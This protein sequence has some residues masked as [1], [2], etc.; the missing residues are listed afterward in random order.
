[1]GPGRSGQ[2]A[3]A[4]TSWG[5]ALREPAPLPSPERLP[6]PE[7][8]QPRLEVCG[9]GQVLS[10]TNLAVPSPAPASF[11]PGLRSWSRVQGDAGPSRAA[12]TGSGLTVKT[13]ILGQCNALPANPGTRAQESIWGALVA[14]FPGADTSPALGT[15]ILGLRAAPGSSGCVGLR[16]EPGSGGG[17]AEPVS[18]P[19]HLPLPPPAPQRCRPPRRIPVGQSSKTLIV[20][21]CPPSGDKMS[22][23][24]MVRKPTLHR[25]ISTKVLLAE[26]RETPF[27][28]HCRNY[29]NTYRVGARDGTGGVG[30]PPPSLPV[31]AALCPRPAQMLQT[32]IQGL[33]DQVQELHRDLTKHHSLIRTEIMSEILQKSLQMDVQ[34][35]AHYSSV[36]MMRS[37]FEEVRPDGRSPT[38]GAARPHHRQLL[39]PVAGLGGD[40]P[41]GGE[42]AG[43]LR[44]YSRCPPGRH[45]RPGSRGHSPLSP[46]SPAPRPAAAAAGEQLPDHHHQADRA[47][48]PLHRQGEGAAGA[49]VSSAGAFG[50]GGPAPVALLAC[51][52]QPW[53]RRRLQEPREPKDEHT[54]T[55]LRIDD[56]SEAAQR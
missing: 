3:E 54:Q 13:W 38:L 22:T 17:R 32:E 6:A 4:A 21:G 27:A 48:R 36:E 46:P 51:H 49:Q 35:A 34:I 11:V 24:S 56:N 50:A 15:A 16:G 30:Q 41:E 18:P 5:S 44:R 26:G 29:E 55:L 10:C 7:L 8:T 25:Y 28:E 9:V 23:G 19:G 14:P 42:R 39:L 33:K 53:S 1:M 45:S 43:D 40:V 37:V 31:A 12:S 2:G 20:P 52:T 47:L